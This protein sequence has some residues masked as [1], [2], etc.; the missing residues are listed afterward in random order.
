MR[1]RDFECRCEGVRP[2]TCAVRSAVSISLF[3]VQHCL[4]YDITIRIAK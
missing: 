4:R 2:D 1:H 3:H